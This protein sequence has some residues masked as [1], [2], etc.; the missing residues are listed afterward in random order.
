MLTMINTSNKTL[1]LFD[2]FQIDF[3]LPKWKDPKRILKFQNGDSLPDVFVTPPRNRFMGAPNGSIVPSMGFILVSREGGA[4]ITAS[5]AT[6]DVTAKPNLFERLFMR[7]KLKRIAEEKRQQ[8]IDDLTAN[9][10]AQPVEPTRD[11]PTITVEEFFK[12]VKNSA[13]ELKLVKDRFES[14]ERVMQHLLSTGQV[15]LIEHMRSELETLRAETQLYAIGFRK[16]ITEENIVAFAEKAPHEL[17]LTWI[18]NFMR[19]I[20]AKAVEAKLKCD[21]N[22]IFDNY[23]ILHY[24]KDGTGEQDTQEEKT[25]KKDPILFGVLAGSTKLYYI[26]DWV[27]EYCDLTFDKMV[28]VLGEKAISANDISVNV[29][30][31]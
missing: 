22:L 17:H 18:K 9:F 11:E 21:D 3:N 12:S 7:K 6:E 20:P 27:D 26:A 16:V 23:V 1:T 14:Y 24:D 4:T 29:Q 15:S 30:A 5:N 25:R 31:E 19:S 10:T 28:E 8:M 2:N 13:E